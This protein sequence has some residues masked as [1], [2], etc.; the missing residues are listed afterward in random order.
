MTTS[1][2]I[3]T[4]LRLGFLALLWLFVLSAVGV[5]R[6]DIFGTRIFARGSV[7]STQPRRSSSEGRS[8]PARGSPTHLVVTGGPLG[9]TSIRLGQSSILIGRDP[10]CTLVLDDDYSSSRHTRIFPHG[11]Q[12]YA[13]DLGSTN[14]TYVDS[15]RIT[16]PT[17]LALGTPTRIGQTIIELRR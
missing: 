2:L 11:T 1:E 9:G 10:S 5:L 6:R 17:E 3:V 4:V 8:R 13:E 7:H 15:R 12:W 16:A 14:G